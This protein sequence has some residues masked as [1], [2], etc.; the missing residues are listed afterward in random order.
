MECLT[1]INTVNLDKIY[2]DSILRYGI[3]GSLWR[4]SLRSVKCT[5]RIQLSW[6]LFRW[7]KF[8]NKQKPRIPSTREN[9]NQNL[10]PLRLLE[11]VG[12]YSGDKK[13]I[14]RKNLKNQHKV[15]L[16]SVASDSCARETLQD[17]TENSYW[18]SVNWK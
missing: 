6:L 9:R 15:T 8:P 14:Q 4:R 3:I 2:E 12:Q 13:S 16:K 1:C 5:R 7:R 17:W 11:S 18:R 10:G